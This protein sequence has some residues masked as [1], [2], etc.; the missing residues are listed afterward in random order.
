MT[1]YFQFKVGNITIRCPAI[2]LASNAFD[3]LMGTNVLKG[4]RAKINYDNRTL[5]AHGAKVPISTHLSGSLQHA[6]A[7]VVAQQHPKTPSTCMIAGVKVGYRSSIPLTPTLE[8]AERLALEN[9]VRVTIA[10][11]EVRQLTTGL[12]L[13]IPEGYQGYILPTGW[14]NETGFLVATGVIHPNNNKT[15]DLLIYNPSS[16]PI[17]IPEKQ[18][19]AQVVISKTETIN[20]VELK[21][22]AEDPPPAMPA[23][24]GTTTTEVPPIRTILDSLKHLKGNAAFSNPKLSF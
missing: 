18:S 14:A 20:P 8:P 24:V 6:P 16:S 21:L 5:T 3:I 4:L 23:N 22:V 1:L 11:G 19:L 12:R 7:L 10:P 13:W 17:P 9:Q 15:I 2:V